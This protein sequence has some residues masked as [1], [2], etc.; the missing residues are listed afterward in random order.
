MAGVYQST[1]PGVV[2]GEGDLVADVQSGMPMQNGHVES[3]KGRFRDECLNHN[4]FS[5]L[6]DAKEKIE[7]WKMEYN[8]DRPHSSLAYRTPEQFAKAFS[9]PTNRMGFKAP[10]PS[11]PPV[12]G[13]RSQNAVKGSLAPRQDRA[14]P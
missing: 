11:E 6:A 4:W 5:T 14:R 12:A 7:R 2:R 13:E 1:F 3:F 9:E 10:I 8:K